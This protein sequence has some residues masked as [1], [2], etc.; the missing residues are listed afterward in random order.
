VGP[1]ISDTSCTSPPSAR[2]GWA[3][4]DSRLALVQSPQLSGNQDWFDLTRI[5]WI[6]AVS[7]GPWLHGW[8]CNLTARI[9]FLSRLQAHVLLFF[10]CYI[11]IVLGVC[12]KVQAQ[13]AT[14]SVW[15]HTP[16][17]HGAGSLH[18]SLAWACVRG[19]CYCISLIIFAKSLRDKAWYS[20]QA[21]WARDQCCCTVV[22]YVLI[23]HLVLD[24]GPSKICSTGCCGIVVFCG[25]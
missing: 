6:S 20:N 9:A 13:L 22:A 5:S 1:K 8:P 12:F 21:S 16:A 19:E 24:I 17:L 2:R 15:G 14:G 23:S 18:T 7:T 10:A 4:Y 25:N 3:W 11:S